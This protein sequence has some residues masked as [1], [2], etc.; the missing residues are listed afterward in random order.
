MESRRP[1]AVLAEDAS[2]PRNHA[3]ASYVSSP[4]SVAFD[5]PLPSPHLACDTL[6]RLPASYC[7][8]EEEVEQFSLIDSLI[9]TECA[10]PVP[11]CP[12]LSALAS[13]AHTDPEARRQTLLHRSRR[14]VFYCTWWLLLYQTVVE[15]RTNFGV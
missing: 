1:R 10:R 3:K 11:L 15:V 12:C 14:S 7:E 2:P 8:E 4:T 5:F 6:E 9:A 13:N